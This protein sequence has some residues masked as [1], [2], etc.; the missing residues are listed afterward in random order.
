MGH[1]ESD[2]HSKQWPIKSPLDGTTLKTIE[3]VGSSSLLPIF[4][5]LTQNWETQKKISKE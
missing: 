2:Q 1:L 4:P 3:D 5:N